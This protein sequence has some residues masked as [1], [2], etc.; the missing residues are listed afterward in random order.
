MEAFGKRV[1]ELTREL[2]GIR[3]DT[4]AGQREVAA[5]LVRELSAIPYF[6]EH[7][8][9]AQIIKTGA[10][11]DE[12]HSV[13]ATYR[14]PFETGTTE[15][16]ILCGHI[17]TVGVDKHVK[18]YGA[19]ERMP[20]DPDRLPDW[21]RET[22]PEDEKLHAELA[23]GDWLCGRGAL[24]MKSGCAVAVELLRHLSAIDFPWNIV[25]LF[26]A[27]E[28]TESRGIKSALPKLKE[29]ADEGFDLK[30]LLNSDYTS[31]LTPGDTNSYIY[32]GTI[33]KLLLGITV[34]GTET[35]AG[36]PFEGVNAAALLSAIVTH[37][38]GNQKLTQHVKGQFTPPPSALS[39]D[40]RQK[41][42]SVTTPAVAK[43]YVNFF[44]LH[45]THSEHLRLIA[46]EV[47]RACRMHLQKLG[48]RHRRMVAKSN[49]D[50]AR[51]LIRPEVVHFS[52]LKERLRQK[53]G[54]DKDEFRKVLAPPEGVNEPREAC[55]AV[56][57]Q[58]TGLLNLTRPTI[59]LSVLPPFYAPYSVVLH[60]DARELLAAARETAR[61]SR[62]GKP[63]GR[64]KQRHFYPYI[65]D[66]SFVCLPG[67]TRL[68][69]LLQDCP[70]PE[71]LEL[72]RQEH[73]LRMPVINLGPW[74]KDAHRVAERVHIPFLTGHLPRA[75]LSLL[76]EITG[77]QVP[78]PD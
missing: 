74:G 65:S 64:L 4:A 16:I 57:E 32:T 66:M 77:A 75:C 8:Q 6:A 70:V 12:L 2:V 59:V 37:L 54:D 58:V 73:R 46:A 68:T 39:A 69:P 35:H 78:E 20:F 31:P 36:A 11:D 55:L 17:D 51:N 47:R 25:V 33:G 49:L 22:F 14:A 67:D 5:R 23:S 76:A 15:T 19:D 44:F 13:M 52:A 41:E 56:V 24:D 50:I 40:A 18:K 48:R 27:D 21:L 62:G 45:H 10:G 26:T 7:P 30:L 38:E 29:L 42:Y 53:L 61:A 1:L 71:S 43:G 3:S 63:V 28:E 60:E 72:P 9:L 34:F